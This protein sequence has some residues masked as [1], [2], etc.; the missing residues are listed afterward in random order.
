M[1]AVGVSTGGGYLR[2]RDLRN[3]KGPLEAKTT[4]FFQ[5][6]MIFSYDRS[7]QFVRNGEI[8]QFGKNGPL[9]NYKLPFRG[10]RN[11]AFILRVNSEVNLKANLAV[12]L[13]VN[14]EVT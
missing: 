2:N 13:E 7:G 9:V 14:L 10:K 3:C 4:V 11:Y 1:L 8:A 5:F 6:V 12:N